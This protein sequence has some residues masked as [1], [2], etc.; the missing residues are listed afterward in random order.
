MNKRFITGTFAAAALLLFASCQ[1]EN[2]LTN[3]GNDG[4]IQFTS[5]ITGQITSRATGNSWDANDAIGIYMQASTGGTAHSDN[6]KYTTNGNGNFSA[7]GTDAITYPTDGSSVDFIAYYPYQPTLTSAI[8][9]IDV[10]NQTNA[11]A[12]DF[13]YANNAKNFNKNSTSNPNL[14]FNHELTKVELTIKAGTGVSSVSGVTA[15]FDGLNTTADF[16]LVTGA[17][18]NQ[19]GPANIQ[20]QVTD[21]LASVILLPI[22]DATNKTVTFGLPTGET[23]TWTLPNGTKFEK[24]KKYSYN[25]VLQNSA[26]PKAVAV[27]SAAITDWIDV[28]S[29]GDFNIDKNGSS[30]PGQTLTESQILS[31]T[32]GNPVV[33]A[34]TTIATFTNF[35]NKTPVIFSD[36]PANSS[37]I[38]TSGSAAT[39]GFES[40]NNQNILFLAPGSTFK[41]EHINTAGYS[42][43]KLTLDVAS[44]ALNQAYSLLKVKYNGTDFP[45]D[46]T[47]STAKDRNPI[48]LS[49]DLSNISASDAGTIEVSLTS[50]SGVRVDNITLKGS[51]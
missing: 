44:T 34:N 1:K 7:Q 5:S 49:F 41:I 51:K 42:K 26:P 43:L 23:Y 47:V 48:T 20:A 6:K 32:F 39:A 22:D 21:K 31:E 16:N 24:G 8:Y 2:N 46:P 19:G 15:T 40:W 28:S 30:T 3:A 14:N 13:M 33:T 27:G 38:R 45:V 12:I 17:L 29:P 35:D 4:K 36:E 9:K 37:S 10:S 50:G 25:I 11:A 18:S